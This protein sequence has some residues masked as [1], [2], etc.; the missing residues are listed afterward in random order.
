MR[1]FKADIVVITL[2]AFLAISTNLGAQSCGDANGDGYTSPA[3]AAY[4]MNYLITGGPPPGEPS[5]AEYDGHEGLTVMDAG[6]IL[7]NWLSCDV[8][9][10]CP[11]EN[12]PIVPILNEEMKIFYPA[13]VPGDNFTFAMTFTLSRPPTEPWTYLLCLPI[14]IRVGGMIPVIDSADFPLPES[15]FSSY[16]SRIHIDQI[17]GTVIFAGQGYI[18]SIPEEDK[19]ATIYMTVGPNPEDRPITVEMLTLGPQQGSSDDSTIFPLVGGYCM[20]ILDEPV[21]AP[22][23]CGDANTD[24]EVNVSDAVRIIN[25]VFAGGDPPYPYEAGNVNCDETVNI[26]DAVF[27]INYV[28]AGGATPC[29]CKR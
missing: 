3:D 16:Y 19:F 6:L 10:P 26:S 11:P 25:Y 23:P 21:L 18:Y 24:G 20:Q 27:I 9:F 12:P 29:D 2:I 8:F 17:S 22:Y 14:Q 1:G 13:S 4:L 5:I 15:Y 7:H 28:F